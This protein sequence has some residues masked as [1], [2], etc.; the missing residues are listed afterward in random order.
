MKKYLVALLAFITVPLNAGTISHTDYTAGT[1]ITAA[2]Q[3]T[4]ENT[5]VN[6][7]NGNLDSANLAANSV[8]SSEITDEAVTLAK[9]SAAV[10]ASLV[11][12]NPTGTILAYSSSTAP[13]GYL[14]CNGQAVD[15]TTYAALFALVGESYGQGNNTTTFNV[16][17]LRGRFLRGVDDGTGTDPNAATRTAMATGGNTGDALGSVQAS[18]AAANTLTDPTHT[19]TATSVLG[20]IS[21]FT[22]RYPSSVSPY[23]IGRTSIG[24]LDIAT[25]DGN[26]AQTNMVAATTGITVSGGA[27]TRPVNANVFYIIKT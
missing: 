2:A 22:S 15:R 25:T 12:V 8:T 4:N 5:I 6:L 21:S 1:T 13:T 14:Y 26:L 19:H 18:T 3:N 17:D 20:A 23:G 24:G 16:P 10:Q 27:E 9:L 11:G 7:V